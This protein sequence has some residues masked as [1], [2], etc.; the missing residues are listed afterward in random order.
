VIVQRFYG[1]LLIDILI[2]L[3][4]RNKIYYKTRFTYRS[5]AI[6]TAAA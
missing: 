2:D 6:P 5:E 3:L 4:L 1:E